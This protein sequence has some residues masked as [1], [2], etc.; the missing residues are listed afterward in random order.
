[1][2]APALLTNCTN[3][4]VINWTFQNYLL[5]E[6]I[7]LLSSSTDFLIQPTASISNGGG[8]V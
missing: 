8:F 5:A 6:M 4:S 1:M 2:V 7:W 3:H